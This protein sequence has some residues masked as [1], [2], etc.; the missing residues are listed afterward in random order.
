[1]GSQFGCN[2]CH[3]QIGGTVG[4]DD[5]SKE[6]IKNGTVATRGCFRKRMAIGAFLSNISS[7]DEYVSHIS[8][9]NDRE[10]AHALLCSVPG[11]T[12]VGEPLGSISSK[13]GDIMNKHSKLLKYKR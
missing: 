11:W 4:K 1:M 12:W 10:H 13:E 2:V 9:L 3:F 7:K 6:D 5:L 8:K